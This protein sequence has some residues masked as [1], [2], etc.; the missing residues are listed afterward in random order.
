MRLFKQLIISPVKALSADPFGRGYL[1]WIGQIHGSHA[2][3]G[4]NGS[5]MVVMFVG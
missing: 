3:G 4:A 2:V 1:R 5:T